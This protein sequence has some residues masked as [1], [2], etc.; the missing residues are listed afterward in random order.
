MKTSTIASRVIAGL[1]VVLLLGHQALARSAPD[2]FADLA[3]RLLPAV[4]NISTAQVIE[5]RGQGDFPFPPGSPM[6]K[7]RD[8]FERDLPQGRNR[9]DDE[10]RRRRSTSLGSGFIIDTNGNGESYVI[11]NNHVIEDADEVTVILQDDTKL[12][13]EI[14]GR[15]AKT[16]LAVLKVHS[17]TP[18]PS[19][20]FGDSD[21]IRVGD[22]VLAIGNPFGLGGSVTAGIISARGRDIN[23]GPYDDFLQTDASINRG[24]SGGPMFNM[25][26]EVIGI[27]TAIYSPSGGSVG[28]GFAIPTSTAKPVIDQLINSGSV[29]RGWLG[30][31][32]QH[33]SEEIAEGLG[34]DTPRGALV[35]SVAD[36]GPS[37]RAGIETGDVILSFDGKKI[38]EM[39]ELPRVV[40]S[41][42][43]GK[44]VKVEVWR[45]GARKALSVVLGDLAR[46]EEQLASNDNDAPTRSA[47]SEEIET[48]GLTVSTITRELRQRY[49]LKEDA[50]GVVVTA[51]DG[52]GPAA[53]KGIR[54]GDVIVEVAQEDV[55]SPADVADQVAEA[56]RRGRKTV[57]VLIEGQNGLRFVAVKLKR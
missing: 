10:P 57:L 46:G 32:I 26:G 15:D 45:D 51:V 40:A 21:G 20:G 41:T 7:F 25:K 18:L 43:V 23:A 3:Q 27:N 35:S 4:V 50:P 49:D 9:G 19:V 55:A 13:A 12:K 29:S 36:G 42:P 5:D 6:D 47:Q 14:I 30:V 22:W 38:A 53:D 48:L 2:S 34:L 54:A 16:D 56:K 1:F 52:N 37:A 31:H 39:R 24:N 11:T 44:K 17:D 33:V 8:F 28:I